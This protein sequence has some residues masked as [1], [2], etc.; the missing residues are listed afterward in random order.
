MS[1]SFLSE[2]QRKR[3]TVTVLTKYLSKIIS[4]KNYNSRNNSL[5]VRK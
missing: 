4:L 1:T 5:L 3:Q 2:N